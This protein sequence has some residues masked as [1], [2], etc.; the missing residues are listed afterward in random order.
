MT[1]PDPTPA[2]SPAGSPLILGLIGTLVFLNVYAPQSLLPLLAR[3]FDSTPVQAGSL[4]GATTLAIALIS[5]LSGVMADA[6]GRK[7]VIVAA[8]VLLMLPALLAVHAATLSQLN[9]A[10]FAQG[11]L[12]PLI[13]VTCTAYAAEEYPGPQVN[14]AITYYVTGTILGGF[15]GRFLSGLIV[16]LSPGGSDWTWAFWL[17]VGSNLAGALLSAVLLRPARHFV[18]AVNLSTVA[19]DLK[20]HLANRVLLGTLAVG[21]MLLFTLVSLFTYVVLY[22][23]RP[24]YLLG[25]AALGGVFAVYLLGVVFTPLSARLMARLGAPRTFA[26]GVGVGL[27]G[28]ALTLSVPL[29]LIVLGLALASSGVFVGQAAAQNAVQASVERAR[30]LASGLYNLSYY[31]GGAA[32]TLLGGLAYTHSGWTGAVISSGAAMLLA[33]VIGLIAWRTPPQ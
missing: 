20:L 33:L 6:L 21:F 26:V 27:L 11:L 5:P 18:P 13:M 12:V 31:A 30:S 19:H 24:P 7:R 3:D 28:L 25:S 15:G 14:R 16:T 29:P 1:S 4:V 17:L 22:L 10:R 8:F 32:A 9:L 23:A 2:A